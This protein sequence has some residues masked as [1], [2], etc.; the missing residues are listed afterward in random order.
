MGVT[1][2]DPSISTL[3]LAD[4]VWGGAYSEVKVFRRNLEGVC[5][6]CCIFRLVHSRSIILVR[7]LKFCPI[8]IKLDPAVMY[9][10][11]RH[12]VTNGPKNQR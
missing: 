11:A 9:G 12:S 5:E 7:H 10:S 1:C 3:N 2:W 4:V 6:G 8:T